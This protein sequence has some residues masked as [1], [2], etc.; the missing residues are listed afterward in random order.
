[1]TRRVIE[2]PLRSR[3][4]R[5]SRMGYPPPVII[6]AAIVMLLVAYGAFDLVSDL[7]RKVL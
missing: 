5:R 1:V 4:R 2:L 3:A 6:V 7:L